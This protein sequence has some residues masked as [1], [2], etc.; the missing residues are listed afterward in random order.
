M[1]KNL[2]PAAVAVIIPCF[3]EEITIGRVVSNFKK[4]LPG[5][6]IYVFDNAST[7]DTAARARAA[8]AEVRYVD[9]RGKG[10]VV[11]RMFA[12]VEAD[13]YMMVDGDDTYDA[14]SAPHLIEA[15]RSRHLDMVVAHR[16]TDER[17][18]Y[19]SGHRVGNRLLTS[20]VQM[21]FGKNLNDMLSGYR[22]LSRRFVKSF[23]AH[24]SGFEIET[25]LTIHALE[26]RMPVAE[27]DTPYLS[28]PAGSESK[29]NTYRDGLRIL[30]TIAKLLKSEKPLMFFSIGFT[31]CS[32]L[33]VAISLPLLATYLE[34]GLVPR[35]PTAILSASLMTFG[36]LLLVCGLVLDTVTHGR[37]E[38]KHLA[39]L[40][41]RGLGENAR[42]D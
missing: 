17:A 37:I 40:S 21:I 39:Y 31:V 4:S 18:A 19:R 22:V 33:S 16:R 28:R 7:D 20:C 38:A 9:A 13:I 5:A 35:L 2:S 11:R 14:K 12:D 15:L 8:G 23:P 6:K 3:N 32:L 29:L 30:S 27:I 34:T 41:V 36:T 25:E 26:L 24:S 42:H 1:T 10:N